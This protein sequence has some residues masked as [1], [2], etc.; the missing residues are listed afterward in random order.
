MLDLTLSSVF[1]E[2]FNM[3]KACLLNQIMSYAPVHTEYVPST[4][5]G[6]YHVDQELLEAGRVLCSPLSPQPLL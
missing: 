1:L 6:L 4:C 3:V 5:C 2:S